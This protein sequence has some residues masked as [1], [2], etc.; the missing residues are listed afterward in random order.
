VR[1]RAAIA[2]AESGRNVRRGWTVD[3]NPKWRT[4]MALGLA[5]AASLALATS[6]AAQYRDRDG[7]RDRGGERDRPGLS[8]R[9]NVFISPS[10]EPFR[11]APGQSY[12][13]D[14]WFNRAD[15]NHDGVLTQD[16]FVADAVA[17]FH[18]LDLNG[19]GVIDGFELT[20]YE[21]KVA[22]EILPRIVGLTARDIPPLPTDDPDEQR[23]RQIQAQA[24]QEADQAA[25]R[26]RAAAPV[27]EG[28]AVFGLIREPEPVAA[29][30]LEF[31]GKITLKEMIAT[32]KRHFAELDLDHDG[33]LTRAELPKTPVEKL[34]EKAEQKRKGRP[35]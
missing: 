8:A 31:D 13:V 16:E 5:A 23:R 32:A 25:A 14:A 10:G 15:A 30:D 12:P 27:Y 28:A 1:D 22:P 9:I 4:G 33:R 6:A 21:Q 17:F 18:K 7:D 29:A 11:A 24:D 34:E 19:D 26:R 35:R 20:N 3:T 2:R